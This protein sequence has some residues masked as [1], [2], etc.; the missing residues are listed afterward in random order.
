MLKKSSK[1]NIVLDEKSVS[2]GKIE[3]DGS[4]DIFG[5]FDGE[6][7]AKK[8]VIVRKNAIFK[9]KI[10]ASNVYIYGRADADIYAHEGVIVAAG[11]NLKGNI[12]CRYFIINRGGEHN[13]NCFIV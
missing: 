10:Y 1:L 5:K 9:G 13:G 7:T 12:E 6:A 3:S 11:G 8:T 4:I 2:R